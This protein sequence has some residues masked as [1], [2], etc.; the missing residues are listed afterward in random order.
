MER[1]EI[2]VRDGAFLQ[3][4]PEGEKRFGRRHFMDVT[5]LFLTEPL[6]LVRWGTRDLGHVDPSALLTRDKRPATILLGG[7]AW[8]V[9]DC[10][11]EQTHRLGNAE[12]GGRTVALGGKRRRAVRAGLP[13]DANGAGL[14]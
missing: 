7:R 3:I 9:E 14:E 5:S 1:L 10:G 11:L 8:H 2:V 12:R 13:G 4:G 6:L